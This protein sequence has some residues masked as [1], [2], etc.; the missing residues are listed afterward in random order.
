MEVQN[1]NVGSILRN[2]G[3]KRMR[4]KKQ[5]KSIKNAEYFT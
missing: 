5:L 2:Q 3:Y 1:F 4:V